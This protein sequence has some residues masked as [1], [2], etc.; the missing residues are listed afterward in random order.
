MSCA[1]CNECFPQTCCN[2]TMRIW[3]VYSVHV[4]AT[5]SLFGVVYDTNI[6]TSLSFTLVDLLV[7]TL[8]LFF[9]PLLYS[10][11]LINTLTLSFTL[12]F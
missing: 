3:E 10:D 11:L 4:T 6:L 7:N 2:F 5:V 9:L 1:T 12:T 8:T